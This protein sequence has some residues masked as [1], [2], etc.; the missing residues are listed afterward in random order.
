[1]K[2]NSSS[3]GFRNSFFCGPALFL[4]VQKIKINTHATNVK[5]DTLVNLFPSLSMHPRLIG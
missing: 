2:M 4:D 5:S 1:M 3:G